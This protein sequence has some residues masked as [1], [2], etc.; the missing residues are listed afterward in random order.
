[1]TSFYGSSCANSGKDALDTP[2]IYVSYISSHVEVGPWSRWPVCLLRVRLLHHTDVKCA[3]GCVGL[4]RSVVGLWV[5][6]PVS[7]QAGL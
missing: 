6:G 7:W 3:L 5:C 4:R 2:E 1:M